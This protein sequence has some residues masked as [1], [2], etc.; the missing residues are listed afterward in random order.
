MSSTAGV[1]GERVSQEQTKSWRGQEPDGKGLTDSARSQNFS[2]SEMG[3]HRRVLSR[4][5]T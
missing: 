2:L 1:G 4:R 5:E 3:S